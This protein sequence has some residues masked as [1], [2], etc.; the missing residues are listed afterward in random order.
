MSQNLNSAIAVIGIDISTAKAKSSFHKGTLAMPSSTSRKA[1][2]ITVVSEL[3]KEAVVAIL[4]TDDFFGEGYLA[5]QA[6]RI[7]AHDHNG[8]RH[9]AT[10]K[11]GHSPC[12][13]ISRR[14]PKKSLR[15]FSVEASASKQIWSISSSIRV[16]SGLPG[17][18]CCW[19]ISAR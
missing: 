4:G 5:G 15:I 3:E 1:K 2:K 12:N 16:R 7:S 9:R 14:F 11:G 18:S 6:L 17:C 19:R 8:L 13:M 10:G